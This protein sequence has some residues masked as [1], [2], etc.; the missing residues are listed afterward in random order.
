MI[1]AR[2]EKK[3]VALTVELVDILSCGIYTTP[4]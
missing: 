1:E 4:V 2:E 3:R